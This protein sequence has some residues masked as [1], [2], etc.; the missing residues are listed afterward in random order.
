[1]CSGT[2]NVIFSLNFN[3]IF[4]TKSFDAIFLYDLDHLSNKNYFLTCHHMISTL[5]I[6]KINLQLCLVYILIRKTKF[7]NGYRGQ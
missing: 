7:G 1:M 3:R 5:K 4:Y 6:I 2:T